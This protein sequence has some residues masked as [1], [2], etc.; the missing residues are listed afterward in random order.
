MS[1]IQTPIRPTSDPVT[2]KQTLQALKDAK[3][4]EANWFFAECTRG[5]DMTR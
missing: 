4:A 1:P 5:L 3:L 2:R